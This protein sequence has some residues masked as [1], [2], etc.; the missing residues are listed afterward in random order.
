MRRVPRST[1]GIEGTPS[2]SHTSR[3]FDK[4]NP[5]GFLFPAPKLAGKFAAT[6]CKRASST[7]VH[8]FSGGP[9]DPATKRPPYRKW[10]NVKRAGNLRYA[11]EGT[12]PSCL[13][14]SV[15]IGVAVGMALSGHPPHRSVRAELPHTAL[16]LGD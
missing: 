11:R 5:I 16:T 2:L 7:G 14:V 3:N 13:S 10:T 15:N 6:L 1:L 9:A 12:G 8:P 4:K